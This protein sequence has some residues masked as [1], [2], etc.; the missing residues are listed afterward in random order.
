MPKVSQHQHSIQSLVCRQE[1]R[2][3]LLEVGGMSRS[4]LYEGNPVSR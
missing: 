3:S 4:L 1:G 2:V